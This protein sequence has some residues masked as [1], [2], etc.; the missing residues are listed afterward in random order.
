MIADYFAPLVGYRCWDAWPNGLLCAQAVYDAWPPGA[1]HHARCA[2]IAEPGQAVAHVIDKRWQ[3][4]PAFA[5]NCGIYAHKSKDRAQKRFAEGRDRT[6]YSTHGDRVWG[7]VKLWGRVIEHT[8]GYRAEYAYPAA[9]TS[10]NEAI[11]REVSALYGVVCRYEPAPEPSFPT[12][13]EQLF[14]FKGLTWSGTTT[15]ATYTTTLPA[16]YY[17]FWSNQTPQYAMQAN[18]Y[19]SYTVTVPTMTS[20]A[21]TT[22]ALAIPSASIVKALGGTPYQQ[23]AAVAKVR[24]A[25]D[26]RAILTRG[27]RGL[28]DNA[29][30]EAMTITG[31]VT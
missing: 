21:P 15:G 7:T 2:Y 29:D 6:W 25:Q 26:W 1:A 19:Q 18:A 30:A 4:A 13:E 8:E 20:L 9:L 16:S 27:L 23:R 5:C 3:P 12:D 11:A 31:T 24:K 10:N 22:G 28:S 17:Y 14:S